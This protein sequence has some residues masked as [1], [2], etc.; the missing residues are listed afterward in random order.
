MSRAR[1]KD[2][3]KEQLTRTFRLGDVGDP[4]YPTPDEKE[5]T[6]IDVLALTAWILQFGPEGNGHRLLEQIRRGCKIR[7]LLVSRLTYAFWGEHKGDM[8]S[9]AEQTGRLVE[10]FMESATKHGVSHLME[11]REHS[12]QPSVSIVLLDATCGGGIGWVAPFT[13]NPRSSAG[14][15]YYFEIEGGSDLFR[16]YRTQ[17]EQLWVEAHPYSVAPNSRQLGGLR[18]LTR[19]LARGAARLS[20]V[21]KDLAVV[22][23][24]AE[25]L[26]Y[27]LDVFVPGWRENG[28]LNVLDPTGVFEVKRA[29]RTILLVLLGQMGKMTTAAKVENLLGRYDVDVLVSIGVTGGVKDVRIGDVVVASQVDDYLHR[30]KAAEGELAFGGMVYRA[31]PDL[32]RRVG[33]FPF[34]HPGSYRTWQEQGES[35]RTSLAPS[36]Q[37]GAPSPVRAV[38][39]RPPMIFADDAHIASGDA[40]VA[41]LKFRAAL[42]ARDRNLL[43]VEMESI[44]LLAAVSE[45]FR[46][47]RTLILRGISDLADE[48]KSGIEKVYGVGLRRLAL[49]NTARF[50]ASLIDTGALFEQ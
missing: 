14:Q 46:S 10:A 42:K 19:S 32:V 37:A 27:F 4:L 9:R 3:A 45:N 29:D 41:D 2:G 23:A 35:Q 36:D 31:S 13:P 28:A 38:D 25:E 11:V 21:H 1:L 15:K 8:T 17:F 44:G 5:L 7:L 47:A 22:F 12:W 43:A 18:Q 50:F 34:A 16:Y 49:Q 6:T 26:D 40:V 39:G 20:G 30:A 48:D 24:L 33:C